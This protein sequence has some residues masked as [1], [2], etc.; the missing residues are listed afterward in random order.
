MVDTGCPLSL[1]LQFKAGR[2]GVFQH[3]DKAVSE[4]RSNFFT[5]LVTGAVVGGLVGGLLGTVLSQQLT[6]QG[7]RSRRRSLNARKKHG[8]GGSVKHRLTAAVD[9]QELL[10]EVRQDADLAIAEARRSLEDKISQLNAAI[11][12]TRARF[13]SEA[14]KDETDDNSGKLQE[15]NWMREGE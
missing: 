13:I 11:E 14:A 8:N 2:M 12:D 1:D 7:K 4:N 5:G 15:A 6:S 9:S 3:S 10:D